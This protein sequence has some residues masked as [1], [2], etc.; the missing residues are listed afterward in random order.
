MFNLEHFGNV[1][2]LYFTVK[3]LQGLSRYKRVE[4]LTFTGNWNELQNKIVQIVN[5]GQN[6]WNNVTKPSKTD[7][8]G[9]TLT[10]VLR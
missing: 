10:F 9:K 1:L 6:L 8:D 7:P 2:A 4:K 3:T 5:R